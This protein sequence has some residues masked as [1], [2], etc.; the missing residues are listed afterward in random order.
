MVPGVATFIVMLSAQA[1]VFG[2]DI[3][4]MAGLT[5][6]LPS[7]AIGDCIVPDGGLTGMSGVVSGKA[8]ALVS[9]FPGADVHELPGVGFPS[10]DV[11]VTVPVVLP[12]T[13]PK[14]VTGIAGGKARFVPVVVA[15]GV[16]AVLFGVALAA[17]GLAGENG[18]ANMLVLEGVTL[19]TEGE[20][21]TVVGEQFTLVPG[22][23]GSWASGGVANVVTGA[24]GMVAAEKRLE[25]GLG[26]VRG[27]DMIA[28][29]VD[30]R[31]IAVVPMVE[32]CARLALQPN[33]SAGATNSKRRI[34]IAL[35]API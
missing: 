19:I 27:E 7:S 10:E 18:S 13:G 29:G 30:A 14:I 26:P 2:V 25:N 5:L 1:D 21:A 9:T 32:T 35:S 4:A 3:T 8:T 24:P 11:G 6:V 22:I 23:V 33:S 20:I 31:P 12:P 34:V 17:F 28:P 16:A 15:P